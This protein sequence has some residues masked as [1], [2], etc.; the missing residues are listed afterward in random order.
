MVEPMK[1]FVQEP[2]ANGGDIKVSTSFY[3]GLCSIFTCFVPLI[4]IVISTG[5]LI[6]GLA[7][8]KSRIVDRE[9][10]NFDIVLN[11]VTLGVSICLTGLVLL[12]AIMTD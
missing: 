8:L 4:G 1:L 7:A 5:G 11:G 10:V 6:L 2:G 12:M 9:S 3:L